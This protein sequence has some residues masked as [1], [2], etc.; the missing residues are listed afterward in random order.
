MQSF[1]IRNNGSRSNHASPQRADQARSYPLSR[2]IT[3]KQGTPGSVPEVRS[4]IRITGLLGDLTAGM[5]SMVVMLCYAMSLGTMIFSADLARYAG[6]G[7]PTAFISCVVTALVI[8]LT[9][10]MRLRLR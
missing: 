7:V 4:G 1:V 6:L 3:V 2:G 5:V 9:S 10:S 8:A